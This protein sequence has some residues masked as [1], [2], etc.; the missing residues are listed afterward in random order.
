MKGDR[1][2]RV[3]RRVTVEPLDAAIL[4]ML[5]ELPHLRKEFRRFAVR[6]ARWP[7]IRRQIGAA[8]AD[9]VVLEARRAGLIRR[10]SKVGAR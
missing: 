9:R 6:A 2:K 3:A 7:H 1:R 8:T 5:Q 10:A 4:T